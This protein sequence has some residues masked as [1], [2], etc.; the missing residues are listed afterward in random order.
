[1]VRYVYERK[2]ARSRMQTDTSVLRRYVGVL[3][4]VTYRSGKESS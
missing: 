2:S 1:M 3:G 4:F